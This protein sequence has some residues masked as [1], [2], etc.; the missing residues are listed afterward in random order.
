MKMSALVKY[1]S[2][3]LLTNFH[4]CGAIVLYHKTKKG[5]GTP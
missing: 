5:A 2:L 1:F 3:F 4:F